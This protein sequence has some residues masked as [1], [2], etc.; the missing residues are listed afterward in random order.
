MIWFKKPAQK[1]QDK[2]P[3][4]HFIGKISQV[5]NQ[6]ELDKLFRPEL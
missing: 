2:T 6:E 3:E 1:Q 5:L 4:R